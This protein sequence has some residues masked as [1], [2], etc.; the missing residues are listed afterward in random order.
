YLSSLSLHD[1]LPISLFICRVSTLQTSLSTWCQHSMPQR[2][3]YQRTKR[4]AVLS[5]SIFQLVNRSQSMGS[6]PWG[7]SIS[8][9]C[10]AQSSKV[11][12]LFLH[13]TR[14]GLIEI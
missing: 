13:P 9:A 6:V 12:Q 1:A 11:P 5:E 3:P 8:L 14:G 10:R 4:R 7:G 2:S